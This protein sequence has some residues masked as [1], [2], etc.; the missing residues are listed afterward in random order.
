[1]RTI[2]FVYL[3]ET[4]PV[5]K[6]NSMRYGPRVQLPCTTNAFI[7]M[8]IVIYCRLVSTGPETTETA[9]N[10]ERR[11]SANGEIS[12]PR[13][14]TGAMC[15]VSFTLALSCAA[16][17]CPAFHHV[18]PPFS[19]WTF[20]TILRIS[21]VASLDVQMHA[22]EKNPSRNETFIFAE[23]FSFYW[24]EVDV[25]GTFETDTSLRLD[26]I[27]CNDA[28]AYFSLLSSVSLPPLRFRAPA[29]NF[30][31]PLPRARAI[32]L[33]VRPGAPVKPSDYPEVK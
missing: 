13:N 5:S 12:P 18:L 32:K 17:P 16:G 2:P 25:L 31:Q 11:S 6:T 10:R 9:G 7:N 1:M 23:S 3:S 27:G 29:I 4:T 22:K 28:R 20:T 30:Q 33:A 26:E 24:K 19:K 15:T 21:R 8:R 14:L